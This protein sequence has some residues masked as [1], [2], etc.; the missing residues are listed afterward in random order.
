M[1]AE[2]NNVK[3]YTKKSLIRSESCE[4]VELFHKPCREGP[5]FIFVIYNRCLYEKSVRK[6]DRNNYRDLDFERFSE[7][8]NKGIYICLTCDG[9]F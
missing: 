7:I 5:T 8:S 1:T 6:F 3:A 4:R 9:P 2:N